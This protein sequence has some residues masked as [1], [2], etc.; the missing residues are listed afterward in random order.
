MHITANEKDFDFIKMFYDIRQMCLTEDVCG[1]CKDMECLVGFARNMIGKAK[2]MDS[3]K[4]PGA[5][6]EL[7]LVDLKGSYDPYTTMEAIAHSLQ[8]CRSC[9]EAHNPDCLVNLIRSCYE[10]ILLGNERPY[11]GSTFAYLT[12]LAE[13]EPEKAAYISQVYQSHDNPM[14]N[15]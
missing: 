6:K 2:K 10:I 9:K 4:I 7:P 11:T 5:H 8:Q 14:K 12:K 15:D 1:T 13:I 3:D